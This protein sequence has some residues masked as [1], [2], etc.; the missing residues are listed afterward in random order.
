MLIFL[1]REHH[2]L[3]A[4]SVLR[5]FCSCCCCCCCWKWIVARMSWVKLTA[6]LRC[7]LPQLEPRASGMSWASVH[8]TTSKNTHFTVTKLEITSYSIGQRL[9]AECVTI[10]LL[11][12]AERITEYKLQDTS[13]RLFPFASPGSISVVKSTCDEFWSDTVE[14]R[15]R[16]ARYL[17]C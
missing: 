3:V 13:Q 4:S 7:R 5:W 8:E 2:L 17:R 16:T 15:S 11:S 12:A 6:S 14:R 10:N 1:S 9:H